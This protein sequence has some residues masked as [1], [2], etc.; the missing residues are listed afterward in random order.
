MVDCPDRITG[1][2]GFREKNLVAH[3]KAECVGGSLGKGR[4]ID[5]VKVVLRV[6]ARP[7]PGCEDHPAALFRIGESSVTVD[8]EQDTIIE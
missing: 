7:H 1:V 4:G 8:L 5:G 3:L 2:H 6:S